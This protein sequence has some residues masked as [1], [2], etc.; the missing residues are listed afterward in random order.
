MNSVFEC[1]ITIC[2]QRYDIIITDKGFHMKFS[3][4]YPKVREIVKIGLNEDISFI[5]HKFEV[6]YNQI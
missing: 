6:N 1:F 4:I 2:D 5:T 3:D